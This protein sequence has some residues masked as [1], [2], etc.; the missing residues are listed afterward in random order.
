MYY[1]SKKETISSFMSILQTEPAKENNSKF[2]P[3]KIKI[4]F[5]SIVFNILSFPISLLVGR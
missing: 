5:F 4:G 2:L 3:V 1:L